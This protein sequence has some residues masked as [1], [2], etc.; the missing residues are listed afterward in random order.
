MNNSKSD[1]YAKAGVDITAGFM[2][3]CSSIMDM[4]TDLELIR[5]VLQAPDENGFRKPSAG[6]LK[7]EIDLTDVSFRYKPDLPLALKQINLHIE[8][9]SF[10]A[11]VGSSGCGKSTLVRI[12]LG[13]ERVCMG[14]GEL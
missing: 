1:I 9:G 5:P 8:P 13:L 3:S 7:G 2:S 14:F 11:L 12:L 6:E 10:V 4:M